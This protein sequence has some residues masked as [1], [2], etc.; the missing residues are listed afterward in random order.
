MLLSVLETEEN[1]QKEKP[2][3][4][5]NLEAATTK[6]E[7]DKAHAQAL[8]YMIKNPG[9]LTS[10]DIS[11]IYK[12]KLKEILVDINANSISKNMHL[13]GLVPIFTDKVGDIVYI[14]SIRGNNVTVQ[15]IHS[16]KTMKF[17]IEEL[18]EKFT[19]TTEMAIEEK[20]T[21]TEFTEKDLQDSDESKD[22]VKDLAND[23]ESTNKFKENAKKSNLKSRFDKL[24]DNSKK[25]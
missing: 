4:I 16:K 14:K 25:C 6:E 22:V 15:D 20:E 1:I 11:N 17:T 10:Q 2:E 18:A 12:S 8:L 24:K 21:K 13:M 3:V 19:K 5:K 23:T 9:Q 7:L